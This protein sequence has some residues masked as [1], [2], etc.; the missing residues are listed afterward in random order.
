M[1]AAQRGHGAQVKRSESRPGRR[2]AASAP[3]LS[4][5]MRAEAAAF[6]NVSEV[7]GW[8]AAFGSTIVH[9]LGATARME[10]AAYLLEK[11]AQCQRTRLGHPRLQYS[12]GAY[13]ARRGI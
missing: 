7:S 2:L 3:M 9:P 8:H 13:Q 1:G 5:K 10:T 12:R 4:M 6:R 11:A